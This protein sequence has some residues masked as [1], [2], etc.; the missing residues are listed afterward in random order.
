M[1]SHH[2]DPVY[3]RTPRYLALTPLE[4]SPLPNSVWGHI[5]RFPSFSEPLPRPRTDI[6]VRCF[7][8]VRWKLPR[9]VP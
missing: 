9:T 2:V 1:V 4:D 5:G 8:D 7:W 6:A 3:S